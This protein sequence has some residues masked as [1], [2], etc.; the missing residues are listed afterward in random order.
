ME[1]ELNYFLLGV[2]HYGRWR[3][4]S[5]FFPAQK[6]NWRVFYLDIFSFSTTAPKWSH[7][8]FYCR[9]LSSLNMDDS[10]QDHDCSL[11]DILMAV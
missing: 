1:L 6:S 11:K 9:K 4:G 7:A 10:S 2:F 5:G 8:K 3:N